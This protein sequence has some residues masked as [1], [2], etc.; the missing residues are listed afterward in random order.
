VKNRFLA[1]A[2]T[3]AARESVSETNSRTRDT[4]LDRG[5][6]R[7]RITLLLA[8]A[9]FFLIT[10]DILIVNVA[11]TQIGRELGGGIVGQ[12]WVVDGYTLLFA[13]LLLFAGNLADRIGAK[14]AFGVGVTLFGLTS[15]GCALAPTIGTLIAARA[16]QGAAA[17]VMLPASM[18]LIREAFPDPGRR[19]RALGV[20][21]VGG[22]VAAALGPLLG[23]VLT[24]FD[25]RWVFGVNIPVCAAMVLLLGTVATSPTRSAPFDWAGQIL[26]VLA[27][28]GVTFG[29]IEGGAD[30]FGSPLVI[31][32]LVVAV[33]SLI[34]FVV[35]EGRVAD[36]MMP[37]ELFSATGMRIAVAIGFAFMVGWYGTVFVGSLFL[38]QQLGLPPLLAGLAF[39]P[40][41]LFSVVGNL[42]SGPVTN[43]FGARVPIVAGLSSMVV[44]LVGLVLAA[45]L[46]SPLLTALLIIPVGA[47][48]SLAMPPTAGLVLASVEPERAGTASA[49]FNT[50]RQ[51]GGAVAIAVFG[52]LI[53]DRSQFTVG[54]QTSLTIAAA[55]MLATALISLRV[56]STRHR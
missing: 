48:G 18:A 35:V 23:G 2:V 14:R 9:G 16:A 30:G 1:S 28:A 26:G 33:A 45:P 50:F 51:V 52:A 55:L 15:I 20:W 49:V 4:G 17:A 39:L 41:A 3:P 6:V 43:R 11:L 27:L 5:L 21:A 12:Q 19:A 31:S 54:L 10:L 38:Q 42:V 37:L 46:G 34:G 25:W 36:P 13:S 40:S 47:G 7:A 22:A 44:G 8:S 32:T 53:A 24:T 29:L 56:R